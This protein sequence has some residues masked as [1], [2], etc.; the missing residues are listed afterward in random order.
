MLQGLSVLIPSETGIQFGL[1]KPTR[2]S[3]AALP[4]ARSRGLEP[5]CACERKPPPTLESW[6]RRPLRGLYSFTAELFDLDYVRV[7][8]T[9]MSASPPSKCVFYSD[10]LI[11][12]KCIQPIFFR[13]CI[14]F[15]ISFASSKITRELVPPSNERPEPGSLS[16]RSS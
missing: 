7:L 1:K 2:D 12:I 5:A 15:C 14:H 3:L 9:V 4:V 8:P 11:L 6:V 10:I 16:S 13:A